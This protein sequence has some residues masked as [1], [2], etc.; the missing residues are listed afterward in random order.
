M[1]NKWTYV[2][3][4]IWFIISSLTIGKVSDDAMAIINVI[5]FGCSMI[6]L[7]IRMLREK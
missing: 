2:V 6:C 1:W 5:L 7:E 3:L 4:M